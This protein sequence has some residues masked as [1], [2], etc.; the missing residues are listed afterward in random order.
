MTKSE[1]AYEI[2]RSMKVSYR[3]GA[4]FHAWADLALPEISREDREVLFDVWRGL[5]ADKYSTA[6]RKSEWPFCGD[7]A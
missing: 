4:H 6:M 1:A 3:G 5:S 2:F 7:F